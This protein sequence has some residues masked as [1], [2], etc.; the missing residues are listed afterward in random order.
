[1][2]RPSPRGLPEVSRVVVVLGRQGSGKGTQCDLLQQRYDRVS[3]VSTGEMLRD[4]AASGTPLGRRAE[5]LMT[6]GDLVPDDV[7]CDVVAERLGPLLRSGNTVLLDGFPRTPAQADALS[8]MVG[9]DGL[10][11]AV[12]LEVGNEDALERML[13]RGR[14]DDT[15]A[16]IARR[17]ELYETQTAPLV[18]WFAVRGLLRRVDGTGAVAEVFDRLS[19]AVAGLVTLRL[20]R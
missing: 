15:A 7:V 20:S 1:M 17:L 5:A 2:R 12:L 18:D 9:T 19:D 10:A 16:G 11:G 4:A 14:A 3:H 6:A 8:E 13:V